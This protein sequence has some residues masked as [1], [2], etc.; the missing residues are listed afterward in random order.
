MIVAPHTG[1][2]VRFEPLA[3]G[4]WDG[5]ATLGA[6]VAGAPADALV[7]RAARDS[8]VPSHVLAAELRLGLATDPAAAGRALAAAMAAHPS[9]LEDALTMQLGDRSAAALVLRDGSGPAVGL[10]ADVRLLPRSGPGAT[11]LSEFSGLPLG[12]PTSAADVAAARAAAGGASWSSRVGTVLTVGEIAAEAIG[13]RG[14]TVG[15]Q[16]LAGVSHLGR[17]GLTILSTVLP[18]DEGELAGFAGSVWDAVD[19]FAGAY[20]EWGGAGL[21]LGRWGL[22]AARLNVIG[23]ALST[24]VF[25]YQALTAGRR[26][27]RIGYGLE[28]VGSGVA[29]AGLLTAGSGLVPLLAVGAVAVPPVGL[30]AIGVGA[31]LICAGYLYRHPEWCRAALRIGGRALDLTWEAETAPIRVAASLGRSAVGAARS[32]I[33]AI[34][35]PWG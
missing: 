22:L 19:G 9:S 27:D 8:Q 15:V 17:F 18:G 12:A 11:G 5:F 10:A 13:E 3:A 4:G 14:S 1:A 29:T 6:P 34:P 16:A 28:A 26:R 30:A 7:L 2:Q 35:T 21:A 20:A 31:T 24:G 32:V 25:G 33:D 23:G